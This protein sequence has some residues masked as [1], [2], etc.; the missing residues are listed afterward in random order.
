MHGGCCSGGWRPPCCFTTP[1]ASKGG[2][3]EERAAPKNGATPGGPLGNASVW[4]RRSEV[5]PTAA[6]CDFLFGFTQ[7]GACAWVKTEGGT[8]LVYAL[9]GPGHQTAGVRAWLRLGPARPPARCRCPAHPARPHQAPGVWRRHQGR[10]WGGRAGPHSS[11]HTDSTPESAKGRSAQG[12]DPHL[13]HSRRMR[14]LALT[15][16]GTELGAGGR[17][18]RGGGHGPEARAACAVRPAF[19]PGLTSRAARTADSRGKIHLG[20]SPVPRRPPPASTKP[21]EE[22]AS[23]KMIRGQEFP[24]KSGFSLT[25]AMIRIWQEA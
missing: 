11:C 12:V 22:T 1:R 23:G 8:C 13:G 5:P 17:C 4:N 20:T 21:V 18:G 24:E 19:N 6:S 15:E 3:S 14:P 2:P 9:P 25:V 7:R 10:A 16:A